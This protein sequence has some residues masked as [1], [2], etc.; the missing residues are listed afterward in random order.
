LELD[1]QLILPS[2]EQVV[3]RLKLLRIHPYLDRKF[4]LFGALNF[5]GSPV[6][7]MHEVLS[8]GSMGRLQFDF[9]F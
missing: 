7:V 9:A 5:L 2:H 6:P 4:W 8:N 3:R 1:L